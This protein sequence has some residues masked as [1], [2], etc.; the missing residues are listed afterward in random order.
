VWYFRICVTE[1]PQAAPATPAA[2]VATESAVPPL[3]ARPLGERAITIYK[4]LKGLL[5]LA[6]A[7]LLFVMLALGDH[8]SPVIALMHTVRRHLVRPW[9]I[10]LADEITETMTHRHIMFAAL[11]LTFDGVLTS[12]EGWAMRRG[13]AW[14]HW[15]VVVSTGALLPFDIRACIRNGTFLEY[16]GTLLNIAVVVYLVR[17]T[18]AKTRKPRDGPIR[19]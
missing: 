16:V 2:P 19:N 1:Q 12:I 14:G 7:L 11:A 17:H 13:H 8:H 15:L 4:S 6:L 9:S 5:E 10:D 18:R 3:S